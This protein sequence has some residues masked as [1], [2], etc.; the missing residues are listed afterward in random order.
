MSSIRRNPGTSRD[1]TRRRVASSNPV[2]SANIQPD[3]GDPP[4]SNAAEWRTASVTV[5]HWRSPRSRRCRGRLCWAPSDRRPNTPR[6]C[7]RPADLGSQ[8]GSN[9]SWRVMK[10]STVSPGKAASSGRDSIQPELG[11]GSR[12][13][14]RQLTGNS[15]SEK[16]M[17]M[18]MAMGYRLPSLVPKMFQGKTVDLIQLV[19][20][21]RVWSNNGWPQIPIDALVTG[22]NARSSSPLVRRR[23][24]TTRL[25]AEVVGAYVG[26]I[27]SR[28][29]AASLGLGRTT[30]LGILKDVDIPVRARSQVLDR[31]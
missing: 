7:Q 2:A 6:N 23:R 24:V 20:L 17:A 29:V 30:V 10:P 16:A 11:E 22:V 9:S 15:T 14:Q 5:E 12:E 8:C 27:S 3:V 21:E 28:R 4:R 31:P 1:K 18:T 13:A 25:R 19:A 26:G